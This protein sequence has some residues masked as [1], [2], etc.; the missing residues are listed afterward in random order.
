MPYKLLCIK[1]DCLKLAVIVLQ[2][3]G[4][5]FVAEAARLEKDGRSIINEATGNELSNE[6]RAS[7]NNRLASAREIEWSLENLRNQPT[8]DEEKEEIK[9]SINDLFEGLGV[10][11]RGRL[12]EEIQ[13]G[14]R[15]VKCQRDAA[16][17]L[18]ATLVDDQRIKLEALRWLIQSALDAPTH[19]SKNARLR[20]GLEAIKE[21]IAEMQKIDPDNI[22]R[23]T[24][25]DWRAGSWNLRRLQADV[26]HKDTQIRALQE[27]L[28]D[29]QKEKKGSESIERAQSEA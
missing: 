5:N 23:Y 1:E 28:N 20:L 4:K 25:H 8:P 24:V 12:V 7:A 14:V 26:Y 17:G 15:E 9:R 16:F 13:W 22:S 2:E 10:R 29:L 21:I 19:A 11:Y 27:Q 3:S 6:L 18:V